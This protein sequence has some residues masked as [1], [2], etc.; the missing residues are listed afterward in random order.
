M[1]RMTWE[2]VA[3][4]A[5]SVATVAVGVTGIVATYKAG[6]RQQETALKVAQQQADSQVAVAREERQQRRLEEAYLEM[7]AALTAV[8]YWVFTVYPV[9]TSTPEEFTMPPMPKLPDAERK[10][11]LWSAYW[12][13][14]VERLMKEWESAV[15]QLQQ[16]GMT[17]GIGRSDVQF[18]QEPGIDMQAALLELPERKQKVIEADRR[19]REQVR[20]E[21][22]GKSDGHEEGSLGSRV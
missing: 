21:L 12:S 8:S 18:R 7:L 15:R 19:I 13:P 3:P 9:F 6:S 1:R 16:T 14:Q 5:G 17:I 11:A 20:L 2:W 4:L 22:L 10:E